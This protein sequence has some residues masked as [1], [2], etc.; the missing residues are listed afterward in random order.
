ML[1]FGQRLKILRREADL[2]QYDLAEVLGVSTQSI[3]K[4]ECDLYYPDIS[5]LLPLSVALGVSADCLLGAGT[6]EK[7]EL[8]ELQK[9]IDRIHKDNSGYEYNNNAWY[10][11]YLARAEFLKKY[12]FNYSEKY[13]AAFALKEYL[14][15]GKSE[16]KYSIPDDEFE[17]L[18]NIGVKMLL[19]IKDKDT[20]PSRQIW[21]RSELIGYFTINGEFD[22]AEAISLEM[23]E[24]C[25]IRDYA[26]FDIECDKKDFA[27]ME[28]HSEEIARISGTEYLRFLYWRAE[29]VGKYGN[30]R[31]KE[32]IEKWGDYERAAAVYDDIFFKSWLKSEY[33]PDI[34]SPTEWYLDAIAHTSCSYL[35]I[36]DVE[37]AL[38]CL[39]RSE[40]IAIERYKEAKESGTDKEILDHLLREIKKIPVECYKYVI[41]D[42]DNILTREERYKACKARLDALE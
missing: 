23:P 24:T 21:I 1:S 14:Y 35:C 30:V 25:L 15:L 42:S 13:L 31:K 28:R 20:D 11:E 10:L 6:N 7:E 27:A 29:S 38:S 37:S 22:K 40:K 19:S 32:A 4:W 26:V 8:E 5:L 33:I 16:H 12:P 2:S 39:E 34:P 17:K 9:E 3:S 36:N 41:S 18:Y